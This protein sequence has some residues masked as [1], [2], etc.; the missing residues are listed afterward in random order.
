MKYLA[1]LAGAIAMHAGAHAATVQMVVDVTHVSKS[2]GT[3]AGRAPMWTPDPGF[4]PQDFSLRVEFDLDHVQVFRSRPGTPPS[5]TTQHPDG[6]LSP[7][8]YGAAFLP[9]LP[10]EAATW[11]YGASYR[12]DAG[13]GDA[14]SFGAGN[15][16]EDEVDGVFRNR[17]YSRVLDWRQAVPFSAD[18]SQ[19][20]DAAA[21]VDLLRANVGTKVG[22]Y[23]EL[24]SV[25]TWKTAHFGGGSLDNWLSFDAVAFVGDAVI[26]SVSVVPEPGTLGL[27]LMGLGALGMAPRRPAAAR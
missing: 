20:P 12:Q 4:V 1:W 19:A 18:Y 22:R 21:F 25:N 23:S 16:W 7:S 10:A 3:I 9:L 26:R 8:P 14:T 6:W 5:I 2:I 24:Y 17:L 27:I 15:L 13:T 11:A